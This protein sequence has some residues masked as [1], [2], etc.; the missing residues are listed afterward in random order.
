MKKID[1]EMNR[2]HYQK[3]V[4][5]TDGLEKGRLNS[6]VLNQNVGLGLHKF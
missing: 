1:S 4:E 6:K 2:F 3:L 5:E